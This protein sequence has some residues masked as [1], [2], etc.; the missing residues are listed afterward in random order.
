MQRFQIIAFFTI[1]G[2][3]FSCSRDKLSGE[4]PNCTDSVGYTDV[5]NII[6]T[7]CAYAGCHD[8]ANAPGNYETLE[9]LSPFLTDRDFRARVLE[10]QDMP[11]TY[12]SGPTSLTPD[13]LLMLNCWAQQGYPE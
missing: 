6:Q 9:G 13:Q 11:P 1:L 10:I 8:G 2:F 12:S 7:T 5:R 4:G 3:F